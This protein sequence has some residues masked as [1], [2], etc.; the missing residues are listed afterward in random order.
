MK[1]FLSYQ[2]KPRSIERFTKY[3]IL[4]LHPFTQYCTFPTKFYSTTPSYSL[5]MSVCL[6]VCRLLYFRLIKGATHNSNDVTRHGNHLQESSPFCS[7]CITLYK[8]QDT[9]H[10][11]NPKPCYLYLMLSGFETKQVPLDEYC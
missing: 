1:C 6:Y 2:S 3:F 10:S 8:L 4:K 9:L 11:I 5:N 7:E